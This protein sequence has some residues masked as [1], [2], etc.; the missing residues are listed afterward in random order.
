MTVRVVF[1]A[2]SLA[3]GGAERSLVKAATVIAS[4]GVQ[5]DVLIL[6]DGAN[7]LV[8]ELP[9]A[10]GVVRCNGTRTANPWLWFRVSRMLRRMRPNVVVAWSV[11]ANLVAVVASGLRRPWKLVLSERIYYRR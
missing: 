5:V 4:A 11:Y 8:S 7:T 10:V 6:T 2:P 9:D 3:L 1:V